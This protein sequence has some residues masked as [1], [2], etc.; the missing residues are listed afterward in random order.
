M[1]Y[2]L[3]TREAA[4][5]FGYTCEDDLA[6]G[7][8]RALDL[9]STVV[10][11][12]SG[13]I[14]GAAAGYHAL[15]AVMIG[16]ITTVGGGTLRD[17]IVAGRPAFWFRD[18]PYLWLGLYGGVIGVFLA[19]SELANWE[20]VVSLMWWLDTIALSVFAAV[21]ARWTLNAIS[22]LYPVILFA[23]LLTCC[24]GGMVRDTLCRRPIRIFD[25]TKEMYAECAVSGAAVYTA[26]LR[27]GF[28]P[29]ACVAACMTTVFTLRSAA[30]AFDLRV[31]CVV[32]VKAPAPVAAAPAPE[33]PFDP[34]ESLRR[35]TAVRGV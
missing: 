30:T 11:G 2:G 22:P 31:P 5:Y 26:V 9:G 21:G 8:L 27:A 32:E 3:Y 23:T 16:L 4:E 28:G 13:A 29:V 12:A 18:L 10:F 34:L 17:A 24:G 15:G 7:G 20:P 6:E 1:P 14:V 19:Y 33:K 25:G 35:P